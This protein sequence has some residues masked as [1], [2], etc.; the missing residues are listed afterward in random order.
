MSPPDP[1]PGTVRVRL[2]AALVALCAGIGALVVAV[3]LVR[4]ALG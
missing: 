2:L 4:S 3:L 1:N